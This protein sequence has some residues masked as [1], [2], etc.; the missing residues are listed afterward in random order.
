MRR[1]L[2]L[3][4]SLLLPIGA[5]CAQESEPQED[6]RWIISQ[7]DLSEWDQW[8]V[9]QD[10]YIAF[11]PSDFLTE[12]LQKGAF[13]PDQ[14]R[15]GSSLKVTVREELSGLLGG[16]LLLLGYAVVAALITG[17]GSSVLS[18]IP[19][20]VL[21]LLGGT[22]VL[23]FLIPQLQEC[24][25]F[26]RHLCSLTE[27]MLPFLLGIFWLFDC[28]ASAAQLGSGIAV[29]SQ[30]ILALASGIVFPLALIGCVFQILNCF[31]EDRLAPIGS[32]CHRG[33]RWILRIGSAGYLSLTAVRG[34]VA[35]H[36]DSLLFRSAKLAAGALPQVGGLASDSMD[37]IWQCVLS[38]RSGI[39]ITGILALGFLLF[40][41]LVKFALEVVLLKIA[42]VL[43]APLGQQEYGRTLQSAATGMGIALSSAV[44]AVLM[45]FGL[46]GWMMGMWNI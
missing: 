21:Q 14:D 34:T 35:A 43:V 23:G 36:A 22:L 30:G 7:L 42:A 41:P 8:Y 44:T 45:V 29:V 31:G 9:S 46:I 12:A 6:I 20:T 25:S 24:A 5:L 15:I 16:F 33:A 17:A 28:S 10:P 32:L 1:A 39:G 27:T 11:V 2:L 37:T 18:G 19:E 40:R 26:L 4:I 38:V 13:D 3:A